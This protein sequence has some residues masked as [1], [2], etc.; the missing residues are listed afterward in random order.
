MTDIFLLEMEDFNT[1]V[2]DAEYKCNS[3]LKRVYILESTD[4]M[5]MEGV[6]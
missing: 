3:E 4:G 2:K 5:F 1:S 6:G